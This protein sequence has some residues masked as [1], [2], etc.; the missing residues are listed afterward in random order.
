M[1]GIAGIS[2][3]WNQENHLIWLESM[4]G[5]IRHRGSDD[6]GSM[7]VDQCSLGHQRLSIIDTSNDG[8]QPMSDANETVV[9]VYNGEIYNFIELRQLLKGSYDFKSE[10]D[11]EVLLAAYLRWGKEFVH[12]LNGMFSIALYDNKSK[13][14]LLIRDRLGEKPLYYFEKNGTLFFSS[15][16]RAL[17]ATGE[18]SSVVDQDALIQYVTYQTVWNPLTIVQGIF[19]VMPG[20]M[21]VWKEGGWQVIKRYWNVQEI[22]SSKESR[23]KDEVVKEVR[24]HLDRSVQWR[25]RCDVSFG[26]FLSGGVDSSAVVGLMSQFSQQPIS[27]FSI[28]FEDKKFDESAYAQTVASRY[29]TNHHPI[30]LTS[31]D[32][33]DAVIPALDAMDHPS[34]DGVNSYV[35]AKVTREQGIKMALSGS[36][37]DEVFGGYPIFHRIMQTRSIRKWIPPI[38]FN[39]PILESLLSRRWNKVQVNRLL[40]LLR[41]KWRTDD[42]VFASDRMMI[43]T[44]LLNDFVHSQTQP[45]LPE[46]YWKS[47]DSNH[48][49]QSISSAEMNA[50]MSH[51]LLRDA[52]QMSMAHTLEVRL[53]MIDHE[54]VEFI[55][56]LPDEYKLGQIDKHLL[57][58]A[59]KDLI[60]ESSYN[61]KKKGF[62]FPWEN[63]MKGPLRSFCEEELSRLK[64][65]PIFEALG[66][67]ENWNRF[68]Q[69]DNKMPW[70]YF[71]HLVVLSHWINKNNV[72]FS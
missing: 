5:A 55:L 37:G 8:H 47:Q 61:R 6:D 69:G 50:Y 31:K 23:S 28:G 58:Q 10:S 42:L 13:E 4:K 49:Y 57:I 39:G 3:I 41:S 20:E 62:V 29:S 32:F 44:N 15:E 26:A 36:G 56:A 21:R 17:L 22:A 12:Y 63:W 19:S 38:T 34:G 43:D 14:L 52:D 54:L 30:E 35:V 2:G 25:M 27:T 71:W 1:C 9:V 64:D 67:E 53:P 18:T 46:Y 66:L 72:R 45:W 7:Q 60:P 11:T 24:A 70:N 68:V 48:L 40:P 59:T 51:I 33:F 65:L 16:I